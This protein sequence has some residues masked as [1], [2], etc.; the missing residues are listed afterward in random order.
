MRVRTLACSTVVM[1]ISS[2]SAGSG[3]VKRTWREVSGSLY[4]KGKDD[5]L[6]NVVRGSN[7]RNIDCVTRGS[8][9]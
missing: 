5:P 4:W 2:Y 9:P 1:S 6:R 7:M 8:W 3:I